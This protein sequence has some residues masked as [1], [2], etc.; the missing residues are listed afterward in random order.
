MNGFN[1]SLKSSGIDIIIHTFDNI[2]NDLFSMNE[3]RR[4]QIEKLINNN[5][6]STSTSTDNP[7]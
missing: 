6:T 2:F 5:S 4:I 3:Y 7:I 1:I